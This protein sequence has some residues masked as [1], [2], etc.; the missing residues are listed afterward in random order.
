M[1]TLLRV[2]CLTVVVVGVLLVAAELWMLVDTVGSWRALVGAV[3]DLVR[4]P[5][6]YLWRIGVAALVVGIV[7]LAI[8]ARRRP[9]ATEEGAAKEEPQQGPEAGEG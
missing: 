5:G 7:G 4:D 2:V 8:S 3:P 9:P 1:R 6:V